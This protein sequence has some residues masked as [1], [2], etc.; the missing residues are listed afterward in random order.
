MSAG[1]RR[2]KGQAGDG[3]LAVP[4][5]RGWTPPRHGGDFLVALAFPGSYRAGMSSLGFQTVLYRFASL[6]S[7][8]CP[9]VSGEVKGLAL[10]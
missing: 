5:E 1:T 6:P 10:V 4:E 8:S 2:G 9:P 3:P 7:N